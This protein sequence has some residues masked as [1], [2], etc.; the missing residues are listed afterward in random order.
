MFRPEEKNKRRCI[1]NEP[2]QRT[3]QMDIVFHALSS[4]IP[5]GSG[6]TPSNHVGTALVCEENKKGPSRRLKYVDWIALC[7]PEFPEARLISYRTKMIGL[8]SFT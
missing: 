8:H 7:H 1:Q 5:E 6:S 3:R 4:N 2:T